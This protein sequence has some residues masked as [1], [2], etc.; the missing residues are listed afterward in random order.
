MAAPLSGDDK[1]PTYMEATGAPLPAGAAAGALNQAEPSGTTYGPPGESYGQP[2]AGA[3]GQPPAGAYG[4]PPAGAYGQP[5]A[6]AYGQPPAGAYK[7]DQ[8]QVPYGGKSFPNGK[9]QTFFL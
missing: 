6:G 1:P 3:Y 4:Q 8:Y 2:P 5:P 7:P 9:C